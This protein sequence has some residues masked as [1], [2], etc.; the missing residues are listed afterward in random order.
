M[1]ATSSLAAV[2]FVM[3]C[4]AHALAGAA[5]YA[6]EP[7]KTEI[8]SSNVATVAV[9][10]VHRPSGRPV[11]DAVAVESHLDM[12][13]DDGKMSSSFVALPS[14]QPGVFAFRAPMTMAGPWL[15]SISARVPGEAEVVVGK[16]EFRVTP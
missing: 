15:L 12:I 14:S 13:H 3:G 9:R 4:C 2:A 16:I 8:K 6:F 7:V 1:T 11:A 10:L 5:D